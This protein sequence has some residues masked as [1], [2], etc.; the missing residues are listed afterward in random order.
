MV[1]RNYRKEYADYHGQ[2]TQ[3]SRRAGRNAARAKLVKEGRVRKNDGKD[4]DHKNGNTRDNS[5]GN[6][7]VMSKSANRAKK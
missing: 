4:I 5:A 6:L 7:R 3:I 2:P 1:S